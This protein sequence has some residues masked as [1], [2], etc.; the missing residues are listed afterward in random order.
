MKIDQDLAK[1]VL[2][3]IETQNIL[4]LSEWFDLSHK[5]KAKAT[6]IDRMSQ[7]LLFESLRG[8]TIL[9]TAFLLK[10]PGLPNKS[11]QIQ[12]GAAMS[13]GVSKDVLMTHVY[14]GKRRFE[15]LSYLTE[16]SRM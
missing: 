9:L 1:A 4:R 16:R 11:N 15:L 5:N 3:D 2:R 10:V 7:N 14:G 6:I 8:D 12:E 13:H